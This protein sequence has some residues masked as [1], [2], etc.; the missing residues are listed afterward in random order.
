MKSLFFYAIQV[1]VVSGLLYGYYHLFLRNKKFHHYNRFYLLGAAFLSLVVPLLNI[2]VYFS[3]ADKDSSVIFQTLSA[4][5]IPV[6]ANHA[7]AG[8]NAVHQSNIFSVNNLLIILYSLI[9]FVA[10]VRIILSVYKLKKIIRTNPVQQADKIL[11]I[12]TEEPGT[13]FSF[14][15]WLF[16]NRKIELDS[17]KGKQIFRHELFHIEQKHSF[18]IIFIEI[19]TAFC[20]FN[21]FFYLIRKELKAIH[22]FLADRF[23]VTEQTRWEYAEL[24]LMRALDTHQSLVNPFFHNQIK[25]RIAMITTSSKPGHQYLRKLMVLPLAV[26]TFLLFAFSYKSIKSEMSSEKFTADAAIDPSIVLAGADTTKPVAGPG[27]KIYE[28]VD[29]EAS[30]PGGDNAWRKYLEKNLNASIPVTKKAPDGAYSVIVQFVVDKDG[31][32]SNVRTLTRFGYGME[33]EAIRV[34]KGGPKWLPAMVNGKAVSAYRKQPIT[35]VIGKGDKNFKGYSASGN[36]AMSEVVVVSFQQQTPAK[37]PG[38]D[39]GWKNFLVKNI[40]SIVPVDSGA[41]PGQYKAVIQF[42]VNTDGSL[43]DFKPIT[44]HGYGM[45]DEVIRL[46]KAGP[47]W[48]PAIAEEKKVRSFVQQPVTFVIADETGASGSGE[49]SYPAIPGISV[50]ELKSAAPFELLQL[51]RE[52]EILGYMFTTDMENGDISESYNKGNEFS[53]ATKQLIAGISPGRLITIDQI[54]ILRDGKELKIPS[55]VYKVTK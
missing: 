34:V 25:R 26:L 15:R 30:V 51:T 23:A 41:H 50:S 18:D 40:R 43:S 35:F 16:W 10:I 46:L 3:E 53:A 36:D 44:K 8:T 14:F 21:P 32:I 33:E 48:I 4:I 7:D 19:V 2:P 39:E 20:W 47:A 28:R 11:L 31:N 54:K 38:G 22:E 12:N 29:V 13:P 52:T 6:S 5:S 49:N 17:A 42:A 37:F 45:E 27:D 9:V 24:L 55:R 1:I